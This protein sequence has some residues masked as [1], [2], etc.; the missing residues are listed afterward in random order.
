M[1]VAKIFSVLG[2]SSSLVP[3]AVKDSAN[4]LGMTAASSVTS[5]DEGKDRFIDEVGTGLIWIGGIPVFKKIIDKTLF[6]VA[7]FDPE[8]DVRNLNNK[9]ILNKT[10]EYAQNDK[11]KSSIEK[12]IENPKTFKALN[13]TKFAVATVAT[14]G[15]YNALTDY[16]QKY[17]HKKV[18][19]KILKQKREEAM[20]AMA[21]VLLSNFWSD[22]R[23]EQGAVAPLS[24]KPEKNDKTS[25]KG[26]ADVMLN[27]AMNTLVLDGGITSERLTKSRSPQELCGYMIKEFGFLFFMY[28]LGNK[29]QGAFERKADM[30]HNKNI[31]LDAR[32][33]ENE[34]FKAAFADGSIKESLREFDKFKSPDSAPPKKWYQNVK[35][36]FNNPKEQGKKMYD[37]V[38][39]IFK[40]PE[41]NPQDAEL[42]DFIQNNPD[43]M[44]VKAAKQS[45]VVAT[46]KK[47][48]KWYQI[49]KKTEDTGV[50]DSRKYINMKDVRDIHKNMSKLYDQY[51]ASNQTVDKFFEGVRNLKRGSILKNMGSTIFALGVVL[52]SIMLADRFL[53]PDNKE[54]AVEKE[55]RAQIQQEHST[56]QAA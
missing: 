14:L 7:G 24:N 27:P 33:I 54:F 1:S 25:F 17:T 29:I 35:E 38:A 13:F 19:E 20:A 15:A 53:K 5:K 22:K 37:K 44:I 39:G 32:V 16:K 3:L 42:Y 9:D 50:I 46:V 47:P 41:V 49:F 26:L 43:N 18:K 30:K 28:F 45:D 36:F 34:Q 2:N 21:P 31:G 11:V 6:K 51:N 23:G 12:I 40:A 56:A 55:V 48:K 4:C 52:P 8:Y 10:K